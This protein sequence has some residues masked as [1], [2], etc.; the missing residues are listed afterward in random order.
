MSLSQDPGLHHGHDDRVAYDHAG[1]QEARTTAVN[2]LAGDD[3][4]ARHRCV[5]PVICCPS[6][7]L[8]VPRLLRRRDRPWPPLDGV[9]H[10]RVER[11]RSEGLPSPERR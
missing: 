5:Q 7:R 8:P 9:D 3:A 10:L 1:G 6:T 11:R 2:V 4:R